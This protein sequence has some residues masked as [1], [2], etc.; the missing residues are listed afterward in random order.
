MIE[1]NRPAA[2]DSPSA[3]LAS[4]GLYGAPQRGDIVGRQRELAV[5]HRAIDAAHTHTA[6]VVLDGEPGIG[7]TR[8]LLAAA[9]RARD[10]GFAVIAAAADEEIRGAF[11]LA[12]SIVGA[13]AALEAAAGTPAEE[14][15]QRAR[16]VLAGRDE[17][18]FESLTA[19]RRLLRAF[20]IGASALHALAEQ[21]PLALVID[22]LQWADE[23]SLRLL[24]YLL[25]T[26]PDDPLLLIF[27]TRP[28]EAAFLT[29]AVTLLADL[30]RMRILQRVRL[31]RLSQLESAEHLQ[32]VLGGPINPS[33]AAVMHAQA[34]G[35]PYMLE[36]QARTYQEAGLIQQ[37]DG[38]WTLAR[39]AQRLLPS[40]VRTLI[41]RRAAHLPPDTGAALAEAAI[42]GRSF[43]LRDIAEIRRRLNGVSAGDRIEDEVA[44]ALAPAVARGLI[45]QYP[46]DS[47]ADYSFTHDHVR[48]YAAGT[49][50][51]PRRRA[52]HAAIVAILT[53]G[54][55]PTPEALAL[56]AR[57]A[58]A[59]G[60]D[61]RCT[62]ASIAAA[63][64]ALDA[65]A[66]E[67]ALR[68]VELA[69]PVAS[70]SRDRIAL[71]C[72][73]DE[74]L[75]MLRRPA[76]RLEG[77]TELAALADALGDAKLEL[78]IL[79][80]RAAALRHSGDCDVA[81]TLAR[82]VRDRA[83]E[84]GDRES[85]L[86]ACME[87]G[88]DLL[89]TELGEG[90]T[91]VPTDSDL[92]AAEEA[93]RRAVEL[94]EALG[95]E[96]ALA[97]ATRE[98]GVI[99]FSRVRIWFVE[100]VESG[101]H[102]EV[103]QHLT[104]GARI[105][106]MLPGMPIFPVVQETMTHYA[107][108]LELYERLEDRRGTMSTIIA[109]ATASWAPDIHL[110]GSVQHI[111]E[112]RR[113]FTRMKSITRESERA[114]AE[115]QMLY[116]THVYARTRLF[117]DVAITKGQEAYEAARLFGERSLEFAAAGGVALEYA[118]LEQIEEADRWLARAAEVAAS[119]P[120]ALR[121]RQ[122]E[123]WHATVSWA[124]GDAEGVRAHLERA[125]DIGSEHPAA[126]A[127]CAP[128]A[129]RAIYLAWLGADRGDA[130]LMTEA[131]HSAHEVLGSAGMLRG[132]PL[133]AVQATAALARIAQSRG[134]VEAAVEAGRGALATFDGL[135]REELPL[136]AILPAAEALIA[137]GT[138]EDQ[139]EARARLRLILALVALRI[140]DEDV[141][142]RWFRTRIGRDLTRLAG[143]LDLDGSAAQ[144]AAVPLDADEAHLLRLVA[145]GY[146]NEEIAS[147]TGSSVD[148][149]AA[150]LAVLFAKIGAVK[151]SDAV[152]AAVMGSLV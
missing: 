102:I 24:R 111:E 69:Q 140:A 12:R 86:A 33:A 133:W 72:L 48:E 22:D 115:A 145:E 50:A 134:D 6:C 80:R 68:L 98:L 2:G 15:L 126:A 89:R 128:L 60:E 138:P 26:H 127:R 5:L 63:R 124:A 117:V 10:D 76:Q 7:K 113:L 120:T 139:E 58:L 142:V 3:P 17:P 110:T 136:E 85:E 79:L 84:L 43:S 96:R 129:Q 95:D 92:D 82:R 77:L 141:R 108:A 64:A 51:A 125:I 148:A 150:Q 137:G 38:V 16:D 109:M 56:V 131:E 101:Q 25:R 151:R 32:Q 123:Q 144:D 39:N 14:H 66:A 104:A 23:D 67:E 4:F 36:E 37:I 149:V 114:L 119:A 122:L 146:T 73:R 21:S 90:S 57:H 99:A 28:E 11:L 13:P 9:E 53:D 91:F 47:P 35:V 49:L 55:D 132:R 152:S 18:G 118:R 19:D 61:E 65:S 40:G 97:D 135:I 83:A 31:A 93:F 147:A 30:D 75:G 45:T 8:L 87:L 88:Q 70:D 54:G 116:G 41:E 94:A 20:D 34:E 100:V 42:L 29:E 107:R 143:P 46:G 130:D 106:D 103:L 52:I 44:E 1:G 78:E 27:T 81:A 121:A 74:A 71:L 112:I 62:K 59:A 105:E